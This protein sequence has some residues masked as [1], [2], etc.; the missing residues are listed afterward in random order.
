MLDT[1][2]C[3]I[4]P[5]VILALATMV[6][7]RAEAQATAH[8]DLPAQSLADSLK[9]IANQ[10]NTNILFDLRLVAGIQA[11]A[12]KGDLTPEAAIGRLLAGTGLRHELVN[13]HTIVL[14]PPG[15]LDAGL[16]RMNSTSGTQQSSVTAAD[17]LMAYSD[18][19][20]AQQT[21][22]ASGSTSGNGDETLQEIVVTA[23]RRSE[24]VEKVP[25]SIAALSQDDLT[26]AAIKNISDLSAV[27]PGLQFTAPGLPTTYTTISI[28]GMNT[29]SGASLVGVYLDET[30]IQSRLTVIG[31][32]GNPYPYVFDLN[33]VEVARGPQGTLFGA[34]S[35]AGTVR[36]IPNEPSLTQFSGFSSAELS[37]TEYGAPSYEIG[38]AAGGPIVQDALGLRVSAWD[39]IEGGYV[40]RIDPISGAITAKNANKSEKSAFRAAMA[41]QWGGVRF[42]PAIYYQSAHTDDGGRFFG[43][44]NSSQTGP[45]FSSPSSG[46]FVTGKLLPDVSSDS[47]ALT[48]LK[49]ETR[50]RFADLTSATSYLTRDSPVSFDESA[51]VGLAILGGYGSPLGPAF[52]TSRSDVAP[53][54]SPNTLT[55]FTQEV[56]LASNDTAA[57]ATWVAGIFYDHRIQDDN[58]SLYTLAVGP[59]NNSLGGLHQ[60]IVD[61]QV[62]AYAQGD[63]HVSKKLTLTLGERVAKV[64]SAL[65]SVNDSG[66]V[67]VPVPFTQVSSATLRE[68]PSTPRI[69][70]SY[71]YD[72]DNLFYI[73]ASKGFRVGGGNV[74]PPS[75]CD[76]TAPETYKADYVW[77]YEVGAKN[78]MFGGRLQLDSS[79]FHVDWLQMQQLL[80]LPCGTGYITNTGRAASN[81]FDLA[82]RAVATDHLR[83]SLDVGYVNAY[84]T[85]NI[86]DQFGNLIVLK[87]DKVGLPPQVNAPWN[88][89]LSADYKIPLTLTNTLHLRGEY[90]YNSRNPGPF[91]TQQ[92]AAVSYS[93]NLVADPPTHLTNARMGITR[94]NLD[95]SLFVNN[96]FNAHPLLG[97][98]LDTPTSTLVT[99]D[100]LRPLT[101]GLWANLKF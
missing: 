81:G 90:I 91:I 88:A 53:T 30:P 87:G 76:T 93:P 47:L 24:S 40:D 1:I 73:S 34:G 63:L 64:K 49:V 65:V 46:Y 23:T 38:A 8:F 10:T 48:S 22:P 69:A 27:T 86:Y 82:L 9:A 62:A 99:Y 2:R 41:L 32:V 60:H 16:S 19:A 68:T 96:A 33:R 58:I 6:A 89:S 50:L 98:Y 51:V 21:S 25:I 17:A 31:D 57:V 43:A 29:N 52:P 61:D 101:V 3:K 35:E 75:Y 18:V 77:S 44:F 78:T 94:G 28:R 79:M 12:L 11:P 42:T 56:R 37:M 84:F 85:E 5:A 54:F 26:A 45:L 7:S 4:I 92:P 97:K 74:Q 66:V 100:T 15:T 13:E 20:G 67:D 71:Q 95:I 70:L 83:I 59:A 36:F 14:A 80:Y 39:R 72:P 55:A